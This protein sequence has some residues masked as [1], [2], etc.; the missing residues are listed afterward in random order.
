MKS[1]ETAAVGPISFWSQLKNDV[2]R[3]FSSMAPAQEDQKMKIEIQSL[4][5]H[6]AALESR[7]AVLEKRDSQRQAR[8]RAEFA[9]E[10]GR[11]AAE[12]IDREKLR[13]EIPQV[14]IAPPL[15][16]AKFFNNNVEFEKHEKAGST[17]EKFPSNYS[18]RTE[19]VASS[20]E[21]SL[22]EAL[23][24]SRLRLKPVEI[25]EESNLNL[26]SPGNFLIHALQS[27]FHF[28]R[29]TQATP[30]TSRTDNTW[31]I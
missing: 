13:E 3:L 26:L 10:R 22:S 7:L 12:E 14:P 19:A 31:A 25:R 28:A 21:F 6:V 23:E 11:V 30:E 5:S 20:K 27:K 2:A 15:T 24:T 9:S 4:K 8:R 16:P 29:A 17:T 18:D 1:D